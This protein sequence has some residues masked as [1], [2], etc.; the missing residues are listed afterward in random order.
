MPSL[1]N[2]E[3]RLKRRERAKQEKQQQRQSQKNQ[4]KSKKS[5]GSILKKEHWR[6]IKK[7]YFNFKQR[8]NPQKRNYGFF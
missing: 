5:S 4:K 8:Q 2:K 3:K 1:T 6:L 7:P